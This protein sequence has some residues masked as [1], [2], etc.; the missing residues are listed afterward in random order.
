MNDMSCCER[1]KCKPFRWIVTVSAIVGF[2]G[3]ATVFVVWL[4]K[5]YKK[6]TAAFTDDGSMDCMD[7]TD[8][9][10]QEN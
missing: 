4:C 1:D 9:F 7:C 5:K 6:C 8:N 10:A 3:M 2:V